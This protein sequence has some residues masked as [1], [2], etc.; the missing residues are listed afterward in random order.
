MY[1]LTHSLTDS[2][3]HSLIYTLFMRSALTSLPWHVPRL[4]MKKT[5]SMLFKNVSDKEQHQTWEK[6]LDQAA[7]FLISLQGQT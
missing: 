7:F 3:I 4:R 5:T 6:T 1:S 2:L